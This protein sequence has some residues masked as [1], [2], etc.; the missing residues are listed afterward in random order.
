M[1]SKQSCPYSN[2]KNKMSN[3]ASFFGGGRGEED[4]VNT[5]KDT[6]GFSFDAEKGLELSSVK[7]KSE[8]SKCPYSE[9]QAKK[10]KAEKQKNSDDEEEN[11]PS[12]GC[13]VMGQKR[14]DPENKHYQA[15][16]EIPRFGQYDFLFII[17]GELEGEEFLEKTK[18]LRAMPRHLKQT[19][20]F[21]NHEKLQLA[22]EKEFPVVFFMY[23]DLKEKGNRLFKK[24]K[25]REAIEHYI[26]S[27]GLLKWIQ[28][29]D[30][31][32]QQ[33]FLKKPSLEAILDDD[34]EEKHVYLDNIKVEE[35]SFK[36]CTV[37]LLM[38]LSSAYMEL[39]HYSDSI[40][41]LNECIQIA[42]EKVPDLF[43]RRS[44]A[45]TFNKTSNQ[46]ELEL[47]ML[48]IEKAISLKDEA[49]YKEHKQILLK[50][51]QERKDKLKENT[52]R[53]LTKVRRSYKKI[54]DKDLKEEEVIYTKK[55][56]DAEMQ[57][58]IMKE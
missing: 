32:R 44:Q 24:G 10:E 7:G 40:D 58:K 4:V 52:D 51:L 3:I 34:I 29:K 19:L 36:A 57:Y 33:E 12:G 30:K 31:K 8:I 18:K 16:F 25:F 22:H 43:F 1:E 38:N 39:R 13:P 37:Y 26:Y 48:D 21:Q 54:K 5:T 14:K 42:E 41:C 11:Q 45:R 55:G 6:S 27:Y 49:I 47:A 53:I 23:D 15:F 2:F 50:I 56:K 17:P 35:D 20:F 28:F 9:S 46:E